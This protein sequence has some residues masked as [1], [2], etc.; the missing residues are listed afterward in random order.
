MDRW[1]QLPRPLPH[2]ADVFLR[3]RRFNKGIRRIDRNTLP[4]HCAPNTVTP[5][6]PW[7]IGLLCLGTGSLLSE[8]ITSR[9]TREKRVAQTFHKTG[10]AT[11]KDQSGYIM[12]FGHFPVCMREAS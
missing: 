2:K 5:L 7:K 8:L 11:S 12:T 10:Y 1:L 9:E 6:L 4:G 3:T